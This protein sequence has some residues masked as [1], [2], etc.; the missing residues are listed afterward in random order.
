MN[1]DPWSM[2]ML[3]IL[4]GG[5]CDCGKDKQPRTTDHG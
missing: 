3:P 5:K 1:I 4:K 2:G